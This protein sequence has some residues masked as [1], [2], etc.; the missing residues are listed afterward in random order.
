MKV[1]LRTDMEDYRRRFALEPLVK[2]V[3]DEE[4][5]KGRKRATVRGAV[6]MEAMEQGGTRRR[7]SREP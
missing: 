7:Q 2:S 3:E 6:W 4:L 1:V 5:L